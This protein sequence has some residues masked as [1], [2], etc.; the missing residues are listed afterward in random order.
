MMTDGYHARRRAQLDARLDAI[1]AHAA[2]CKFHFAIMDKSFA[3]TEH[4][5]P[6]VR[7]DAPLS[8]AM[9][10]ACAASVEAALFPQA[11]ALVA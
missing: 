5:I 8:A 2:E 9:Q 10:D 4:L 6:L 1:E 3:I 11:I 7:F